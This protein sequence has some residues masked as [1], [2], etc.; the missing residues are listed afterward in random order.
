LACAKELAALPEYAACLTA[1]LADPK[2]KSQLW[3]MV[4]TN[5]LRTRSSDVSALMSR[6]VHLGLPRATYTFNPGE[7]LTTFVTFLLES[8]FVP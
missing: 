5:G 6:L 8:F 4:G 1:L 3:T 7:R 2:I